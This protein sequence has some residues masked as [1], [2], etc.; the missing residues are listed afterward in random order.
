[1]VFTRMY[2]SYYFRTHMIC[3]RD[4]THLSDLVV[5]VVIETEDTIADDQATAL[6]LEADLAIVTVV[7]DA[8]DPGPDP[9][10]EADTAGEIAGATEGAIDPDRGP[11]IGTAAETETEACLAIAE[12]GPAVGPPT[13]TERRAPRLRAEAEAEVAPSHPR[14]LALAPEATSAREVEAGV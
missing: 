9:A 2:I 3:L 7:E 5:V 11:V 13:G 14:S 8:L 1:M 6:A 10:I 12:E 4:D